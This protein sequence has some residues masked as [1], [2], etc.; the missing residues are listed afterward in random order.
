MFKEG[1]HQ[2]KPILFEIGE[3]KTFILEFDWAREGITPDWSVTAYAEK[4]GVSVSHIE[5]LA[6]AELPHLSIE[7]ELALTTA[8]TPTTLS[9]VT[10]TL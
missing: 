3:T 9:S 10:R 8:T 7:T 4:G 1:T 2:M 6:S 5:G